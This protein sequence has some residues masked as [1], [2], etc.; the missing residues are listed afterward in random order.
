MGKAEKVRI[1]MV[2]R[3]NMTAAA[4]AEKMGITAQALGRKLN[5]EKFT[6]PD[7][8][9]IAKILNCTWNVECREWFRMNDTGEEI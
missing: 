2:K 1:L 6:E 5:K 9:K 4:L 3:G 7:M 8:E